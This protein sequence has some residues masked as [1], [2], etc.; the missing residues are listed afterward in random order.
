[1]VPGSRCKG[2]SVLS[3]IGSLVFPASIYYICLCALSASPR[4]KWP[5]RVTLGRLLPHA[6]GLGFKPRREG[7]PS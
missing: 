7:F 6:R 5:P 1:M 4:T 2:R 3:I